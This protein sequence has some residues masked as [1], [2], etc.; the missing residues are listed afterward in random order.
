MRFMVMHKMTD[1]ME[2]GLAPDPAVIE[3]VGKLIQEGL[4]ERVFVSGEGLK[5]S[6]ERMHVV[7]ENGMR[8][9]TD[10]PFSEAKELVAGFGL[11]RVHSKEEALGWCDRFAAVIGDHELFLGAVVEPWV[12]CPFR[13]R[14]RVRAA[15]GGG[16]VG[17]RELG[18]LQV[19]RLGTSLMETR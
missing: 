11:M 18:R 3:G 19:N 6:S 7:Y 2:R 5:P 13:T 4:E 9:V 12:W 15:P 14:R 1:E 17:S 8:T 16:V 10:G